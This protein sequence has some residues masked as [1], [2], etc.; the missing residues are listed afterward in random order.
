MPKVPALALPVDRQSRFETVISTV[1]AKAQVLFQSIFELR[2]ATS[3]VKP[4][5]I[6]KR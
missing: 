4:C 2:F 5:I 3:W 1:R 6:D